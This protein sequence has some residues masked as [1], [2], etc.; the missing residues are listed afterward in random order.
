[1]RILYITNIFP[2]SPK[3]SRGRFIY[4]SIKAVKDKGNKVNI[5]V[6][7]TFKPKIIFN[8]IKRNNDFCINKNLFDNEIIIESGN[9]LSIPRNFYK[10]ISIFF[11]R[12][13]LLPKI[14]DHIIKFEPKIIHCHDNLSAFI[15]LP[16]AKKLAIPVCLTIHGVDTSNQLKNKYM[17]NITKKIYNEVDSLFVVGKTIIKDIRCKNILEKQKKLYFIPNGIKKI[18]NKKRKKLI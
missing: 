11:Y 3:D 16:F 15:I 1:M 17:R 4:E 7:N 14:K 9:Y 6:T 12:K 8:L 5:F 10:S 18:K 13:I 2:K